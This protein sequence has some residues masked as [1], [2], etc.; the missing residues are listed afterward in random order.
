MSTLKV[1][2][3]LTLLTA[4]LVWLGN[5]IGGQAGMIIALVFAAVMNIGSFWFSD[6]IVLAMT[7]AQ[8]LEP[9]QAPRLFQLVQRLAERAGVP[10]PKLYVVPDPSPNAFATGRNPEHGI[11]AVNQGLLDILDQEEV[12]GVIAHEIGHIKHRDTLTM[13]IVATMAGAVMMIANLLQFAAFFGGMSRDDD[14]RGNPL[15]MLAAAFLA[16]IAATLIQ[17]GISRAREYEADRIGAE[18]AGSGRGLRD[19][20]VK[21]HRGVQAVPGHTPPQAAHLNIVNPFTG[22]RGMAALFSTHPPVEERVRRLDT[23]EKQLT[24]AH[25]SMRGV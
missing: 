17:M 13:A 18:I 16:P 1:G 11:V 5:F 2:I 7:R 4:L 15:G 25:A 24:G 8:P 14:E 10:M 23:M 9:S 21:L 3:L 22:L 12:E 6:K 20:L 19:A